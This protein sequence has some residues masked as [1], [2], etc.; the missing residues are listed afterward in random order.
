MML[1][2]RRMMLMNEQEDGEM[3]SIEYVGQKIFD[4]DN[5]G[6]TLI[7][8]LK[9]EAGYTY[10]F[11]RSN[12]QHLMYAANNGKGNYS[13]CY[14]NPQSGYVMNEWN[15]YPL[16]DDGTI[17]CDVSGGDTYNTQNTYDVYRYKVAR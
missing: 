13:M 3:G 6:K 14:F 2:R 10:F 16:N 11:A 9:L 1:N 15:N 8:N 4:S 17:S 12:S 5:Y 7:R